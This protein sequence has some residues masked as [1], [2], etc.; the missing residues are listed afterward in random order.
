MKT[1][2]KDLKEF[3]LI[4]LSTIEQVDHIL[5]TKTKRTD[6]ILNL[7]LKKQL[8]ARIINCL[9]NNEFENARYLIL[10]LNLNLEY[11]YWTYCEVLKDIAGMD[12]SKV[13]YIP[14]EETLRFFYLFPD[15]VSTKEQFIEN[16]VYDIYEKYLKYSK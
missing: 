5:E 11:R 10:F 13:F 2:A 4:I 15:F 14:E 6:G 12:M 8:R 3:S 9:I 1:I 16:Q 7:E